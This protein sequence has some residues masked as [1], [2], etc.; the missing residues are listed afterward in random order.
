MA[1]IKCE[2]CGNEYSDKAARCPKCGCPN[3]EI[4]KTMAVWKTGRTVIGMLSLILFVLISFQSCA[5]GLGNAIDNN[6]SL[7]GTAGFCLAICMMIAGIIA[8]CTRKSVNKIP[9][10][11]PA[12][13]YWFGSLLTIGSGDTYGDL[14]IWGTLSFIF[15]LVFVVAC[16]KQKK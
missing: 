1:M 2:D 14:P 6:N 4:S 11:L 13:F 16:Y 7:S 3:K 15:G 5:A 10:V 12:L 9:T 8:I